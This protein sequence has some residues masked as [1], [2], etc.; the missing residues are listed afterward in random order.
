MNSSLM[1][2]YAIKCFILI[3]NHLYNFLQS[4]FCVLPPSIAVTLTTVLVLPCGRKWLLTEYWIVYQVFSVKAMRYKLFYCF[5]YLCLF[6]LAVH[7][8]CFVLNVELISFLNG[9]NYN[10]VCALYLPVRK[11]E[12]SLPIFHYYETKTEEEKKIK[13]VKCLVRPEK[14]KKSQN[15]Y[16]SNV[17]I[18]EKSRFAG[19]KAF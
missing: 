12:K 9:G 1:M 18:S 11:R 17:W 8:W 15:I 6:F 2:V 19:G 16:I 7:R 4:S 13:Y 3:G 10:E 5:W 14:R